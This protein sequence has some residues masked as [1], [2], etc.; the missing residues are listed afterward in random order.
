VISR[1]RAV[2]IPVVLVVLALATTAAVWFRS[3]QEPP[4]VAQNRLGTV[5]LVPGRA[6]DSTALVDLQ[7][8]LFLTGR[9]AI[10]ISTGIEDAGDLRAP[11]RQ[12][13]ETA[14]KAVA[15]GAPSVDVVGYSAGG[16]VTRLWLAE[17]GAALA[18]RVVTIASPHQGATGPQLNHLVTKNHCEITCPQLSPGS[19]L[20][21]ELPAAEGPAPWLN[22]WTARDRVVTESSAQL[23]GALNVSLQ[24]VC[25]K[26]RVGHVAIPTDPLVIGIVLKALAPA[27]VTTAPTEQECA[28][29]RSN[30]T[31]DAIPGVA[32]TT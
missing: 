23:P 27:P 31:P 13:Q 20:L 25:P 21:K 4:P 11:A 30:G 28:A 24:S 19:S 12:V 22:L 15:S 32:A 14:E 3:N 16:I 6:A 1:R 18:R 2:V 7:R 5:L 8:R 10:I 26:S 9:R 29:L 17:G